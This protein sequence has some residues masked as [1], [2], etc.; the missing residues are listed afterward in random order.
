MR[1]SYGSVLGGN[2][3]DTK[4]VEGDDGGSGDKGFPLTEAK[5]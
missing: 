2:V 5:R 4:W 1:I 3:V